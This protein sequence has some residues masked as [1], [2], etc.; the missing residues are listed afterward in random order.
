MLCAVWSHMD[1]GFKRIQMG[2]I[3]W[4]ENRGRGLGIAEAYAVG[5]Q[6]LCSLEPI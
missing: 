2:L 5:T 3:L 4:G 1:V 6:D